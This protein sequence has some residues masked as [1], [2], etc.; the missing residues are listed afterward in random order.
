MKRA[1]IS[2]WDTDN[3]YLRLVLSGN[4]VENCSHISV[5]HLWFSVAVT[6]KQQTPFQLAKAKTKPAKKSRQLL[7]QKVVFTWKQHSP[8]K[9]YSNK[10]EIV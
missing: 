6:I 1:T 3:M 4:S 9:Q 7:L 10:F 2:P 8:N 5:L